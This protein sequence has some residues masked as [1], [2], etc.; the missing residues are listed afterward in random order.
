MNASEKSLKEALEEKRRE[1]NNL[2]D[3]ESGKDEILKVSQEMDVL[4]TEWHK[5]GRM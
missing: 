4:L 5:S 2:M 1:L 3:I